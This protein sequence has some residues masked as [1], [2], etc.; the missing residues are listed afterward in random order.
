[1]YLKES[2]FEG[3]NLLMRVNVNYE[4]VKIMIILITLLL[5]S[6]VAFGPLNMQCNVYKGNM[7]TLIT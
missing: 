1:M 5:I 2:E 3:Y 4:Q 6:P 7:L